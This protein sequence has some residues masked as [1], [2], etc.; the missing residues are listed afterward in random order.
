MGMFDFLTAP[1]AYI[2]SSIVGGLFGQSGQASANAANQAQFDKQIE[3]ANTAHQREVADLKAAGLNP[4]L[5]V[6]KG[7]GGSSVPN[8]PVMQNTKGQLGQA[9][10][11]SAQVGLM[12]AQTRKA[13]AEANVTEQVGLDQA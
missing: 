6:S 9:L 4:M 5:S 13:N 12:N 10:M 1:A 3:L 2:G 11:N 8:A 7:G